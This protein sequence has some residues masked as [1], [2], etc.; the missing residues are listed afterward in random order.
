MRRISRLHLVDKDKEPCNPL[1]RLYETV[2]W[3]RVFWVTSIVMAARVCP[4]FSLKNRLYRLLGMR[5]GRNT[6][7]AFDVT[8]DLLHPEWISIGKNCVIGYNTTILTH[9][10][11]VTEYRFG[12][13]VVGDN[14]MIGANATILAGVTIGNRAVV[15]AGA[16][17]TS[18]VP[19]GAFVAGVPA[20]V[21]EY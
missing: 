14:V 4:F 12:N 7:I 1:Y 3:W 19:E 15:A 8:M 2:P 17:V 13:V 18:D 5:I 16:V 6:A 9:E 11:L 10:Y 21:I 20:R